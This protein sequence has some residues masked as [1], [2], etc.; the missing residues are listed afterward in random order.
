MLLDLIDEEAQEALKYGNRVIWWFWLFLIC[1][2]DCNFCYYCFEQSK[3]DE[4]EEEED[5][6]G[7]DN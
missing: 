2:S 5:S 7:E 6:D 3:D 4:S 1:G